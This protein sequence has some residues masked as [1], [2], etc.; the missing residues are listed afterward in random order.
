MCCTWFAYDFAQATWVYVLET[1]RGA[2]KRLYKISN[3]AF[4]GGYYLKSIIM[5]KNKIA[6]QF[7]CTCVNVSA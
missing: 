4:E 7:H 1:V 6:L 2:V 3:G 5:M